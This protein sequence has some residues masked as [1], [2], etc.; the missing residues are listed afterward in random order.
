MKSCNA[1]MNPVYVIQPL[2]QE[3]MKVGVLEYR[4]ARFANTKCKSKHKIHQLPIN[5]GTNIK[6]LERLEPYKSNLISKPRYKLKPLK[7]MVFDH[8]SQSYRLQYERHCNEAPVGVFMGRKI[9]GVQSVAMVVASYQDNRL[10]QKS[11]N[12]LLYTSPSPRDRG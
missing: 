6:N 10:C 5:L 2:D 9:K 7:K 11:N 12:C 4:K 3:T 1:L 8:N